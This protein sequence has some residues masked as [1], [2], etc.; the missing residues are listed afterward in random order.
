MTNEANRVA[1]L[2]RDAVPDPPAGIDYEQVVKAGRRRQVATRGAV[3]LAVAGCVLAAAFGVP[4][5][6]GETRQREQQVLTA[7][8]VPEFHGLRYPVPNGWQVAEGTPDGSSLPADRTVA[9]G[10]SRLPGDAKVT[11]PLQRTVQL[12]SFYGD[13]ARSDDFYA[14]AS[15]VYKVRNGQPSWTDSFG[16]E[17]GRMVTVVYP[18]LNAVVAATAPNERTARALAD[19]VQVPAPTEAWPAISSA[20]RLELL[21]WLDVEGK[22][23]RTVTDQKQIRSILAALGSLRPLEDQPAD[24]RKLNS[25]ATYVLTVRDADGGGDRAYLIRTGDLCLQVNGPE[26]GAAE[27]SPTLLDELA[28]AFDLSGR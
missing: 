14:S 4:A 22:G 23:P 5:L 13:G 27:L 20:S 9:V 26:G 25:M 8:P 18:W 28:R 7:P 15:G 16:Y 10:D 19:A 1:Q 11:E 12:R 2:L 6:L 17:G 21:S 3:A 24:C